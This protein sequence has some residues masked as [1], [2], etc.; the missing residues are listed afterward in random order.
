[1]TEQWKTVPVE[2]TEEI[3]VA[4]VKSREGEAVYKCVNTDGCVHMERQALDDY[5]AALAAAPPPP[6]CNWRERRS[7]MYA[8][9]CLYMAASGHKIGDS[10]FCCFC[11]HPIAAHPYKGGEE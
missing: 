1:M 7:G 2:P 8:T 6:A 9:D 10:K 4:M 5:Q 3:L 11:G